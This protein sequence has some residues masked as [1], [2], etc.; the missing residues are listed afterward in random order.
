MDREKPD[1]VFESSIELYR[2][3][4][5][6]GLHLR[7]GNGRDDALLDELCNSIG[8]P[9][10]QLA[11]FLKQED[12]S[13]EWFMIEFLQL[14]TPFA[15]MFS[16]I[17]NFLS[18]EGG[19]RATEEIRIRFGFEEDDITEVDLEEFREWARTARSLWIDATIAYWPDEAFD[20]LFGLARCVD[21][22]GGTQGSKYRP[23]EPYQLPTID[24]YQDDDFEEIV[25]RVRNFFQNVI[26]GAAEIDEEEYNCNVI[27]SKNEVEESISSLTLTANH[28]HDL[29][30]SWEQIF[31]N[32][33]EISEENR[34]QA[35]DYYRENIAPKLETG[36]GVV[37]RDQRTPLDI[38][39]LPF[40]KHRWHTYEIW[41]TVQTLKALDS[42]DPQVRVVD[43]RIPIDGRS[44]EIVAELDVIGN[45]D[46]CVVTELETPFQTKDRTAIRPDLSI[47]RT[48]EL[49]AN[50]RAVVIEYKQRASLSSSHVKE[51]AQSYLSG[52]PAAVGLAIV[53]Y[54]AVPDVEL[55]ETA[56]LLG[57]VRPGSDTV[58]KYREIVK[59]L[60]KET[61]LLGHLEQRTV[62]IDVSG[63]MGNVYANPEVQDAL[64]NLLEWKE[65]GLKVYQFDSGL[66]EH[67]QITVSE[68][69][70]GLETG[71]GTDVTRAI[72][73]VCQDFAT[74]SILLVVTDV[75]G[76]LS[77]SVSEGIETIKKC[78]PQDLPSELDWLWRGELSP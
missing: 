21:V 42:C 19:Q 38:L 67:P 63:S 53:N 37:V 65:K 14:V 43:D 60:M 69:E 52:S 33:H 27:G 78:S 58:N 30:P 31:N 76:S 50:S 59:D 10:N 3:M 45:Y 49:D 34:R 72:E 16:E 24:T 55:S 9:D 7:H 56:E 22:K 6:R 39:R 36:S 64:K 12:R 35:V 26:D 41:M 48:Q 8:C 32:H 70:A 73:E 40:W 28:L 25:R 23:Q 75:Q 77:E 1:R 71:G 44:T 46:A 17:W 2:E 66:T 47:C 57:N 61:E 62:L 74:P 13:A 11:N 4:R 29:L 68:V 15:R 5:R 18:N 51:V 20:E 54:D